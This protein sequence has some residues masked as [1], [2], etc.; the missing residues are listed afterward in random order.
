MA[1]DETSFLNGLALGRAMKGVSM[2]NPNRGD[3]LRVLSGRLAAV[4]IIALTPEAL[5]GGDWGCAAVMASSL[6]ISGQRIRPHVTAPGEAGCGGLSAAAVLTQEAERISAAAETPGEM[7]AAV[8][9][10]IRRKA[11]E[12]SFRT[13]DMPGGIGGTVQAALSIE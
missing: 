8:S 7:T 4:R 12:G 2:A 10:A 3:L 11:P 9:A 6:E 13:E 1:Y 5:T